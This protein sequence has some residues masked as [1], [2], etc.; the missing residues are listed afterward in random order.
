[1]S[2]SDGPSE[3]G[4]FSGGPE[5]DDCASLRIDDVVASPDPGF[6]FA[7]GLLFDVVLNVGPPA[8]VSLVHRG[9]RAGSL[10]PRPALVRCLRGGVVFEAEVLSASGGDIKVRVAPVL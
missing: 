4:M 8:T 10:H 6:T 1:M 9:A 2:G 5:P 3:G 7:V